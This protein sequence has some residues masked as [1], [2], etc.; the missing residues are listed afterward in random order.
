MTVP[1]GRQFAADPCTAFAACIHQKTG[2][3]GASLL[4][5]MSRRLSPAVPQLDAVTSIAVTT[6]SQRA[7]SLA[8][9]I[10]LVAPGPR[11]RLLIGGGPEVSSINQIF[12]LIFIFA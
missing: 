6:Q 7:Y 4:A 10:V 9:Q 8:M 1:A 12:G 5:N 3:Q 2:V 11:L